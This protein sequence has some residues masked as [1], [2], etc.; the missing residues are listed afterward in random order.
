M[1]STIKTKTLVLAVIASL[2]TLTMTGSAANAIG[3]L[4]QDAL[5]GTSATVDTAAT[6]AAIRKLVNGRTIKLGFAP[7]ILSEAYTIAQQGA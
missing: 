4:K 1:K 3:T 2:V 6:D 7:P 5:T